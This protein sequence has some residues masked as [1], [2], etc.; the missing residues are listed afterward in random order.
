MSGH[1]RKSWGLLQPHAKPR[2]PALGIVMLLGGVLAT[3]QAAP[4]LLLEPLW[5]QVLFPGGEG[6][7]AAGDPSPVQRLFAHLSGL[8][9]GA[10][11]ADLDVDARLRIL[12]IVVAVAVAI[13]IV[14][15][16]AQF[17]YTWIARRVG[18][19]MIVDLRMRIARH[20]MNLS[21]RYHGQRQLGD[22]LSRVSA[23]VGVTLNAV[24][25][26]LKS[27][28]QEP[29]IALVLMGT[30]FYAA[31]LPTIGILLLLPVLAWPVSRLSGKV[32]RSSTKS[33][34]TLGA[35]V[36]VLTQMF[37]GVRTVK[38]F[39]AEER[40]LDRYAEINDDYF[41]TS[42]KVVRHIAL[43]HSWTVFF[44][45][46]GL[47]VMVAVLGWLTVSHGMFRGGEQMM[48]FFG[49][50][51]LAS[52]HVKTFAK[53][54]T[55]VQESAGAC[56]RLQQ[57]L[58]ESAD[59]VE[60]PNAVAIDSM[61]QGIRFEGVSFRYPGSTE[62]A[63]EHVTLDV[64]P[65]ET[66]ALVGPSGAGKS[67]LVD[68]I[69][70]FIDVTDGRIAVDGVD[71]RE[72]KLGDWTDLYALV[73]QVPFLF[74]ASIG[75]NIAYGRPGA[76]QEEIEE[77]SRAAHIHEFIRGLPEGYATDV[78]DMGTR[79][80][81]GQRQR[82]TIARA[83]LKGAPLLLLDEATSALDS[84]SEAEVQ[85]A[86]ER[87]MKGRT[88]IVIAHRLS[89]IQNADRIAV[90]EA[91]RLVEVGTHDELV[92]AKGTYAR[93]WSLQKLGEAE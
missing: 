17:L 54:L 72:L 45:T 42:M 78:A 25:V 5:R 87:L 27:F 85:R 81:G 80:S 41:R 15:A 39:R 23:D 83:L 58:D 56:E 1:L 67:T 86:L 93:L 55:R 34:T 68:L 59:V 57:L 44:S 38:A 20:L 36:Q 4:L 66:L 11:G 71:L 16:G 31:P 79:L 90:L 47:A 53:A 26:G 14:G 6:G 76:T 89:T 35:S 84:E 62:R 12:W 40:E 22:L 2:L 32:R 52:N 74:H 33:L 70:R 77:A 10:S 51:M 19:Q 29:I 65:G 8:E 24:N 48:I 92:R 3:V 7:E 30:A 49:S 37:Q 13:A 43:T 82:I 9:P 28:I 46:A 21:L 63:L 61:R 69:A 91:G 18:F 73:G 75:E 50:V 64:R 88:V 60:S